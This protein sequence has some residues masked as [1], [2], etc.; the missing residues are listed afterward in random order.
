MIICNLDANCGALDDIENLQDKL[1]ARNKT[2]KKLKQSMKELEICK[3]C[4]GLIK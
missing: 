3:L 2:I 4:K 1:K